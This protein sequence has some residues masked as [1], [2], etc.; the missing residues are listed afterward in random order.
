MNRSHYACF[1]VLGAIALASAAPAGE[2]DQGALWTSGARADFYSRA[3]GSRVMPLAWITALKQP[4]GRPF[5]EDSLGRYGYLPNPTSTPPGLPVGFSVAND[6]GG[7][8][9]GITCA[10]CHTREI[11]V[12]G[13]HYRIDGGPAIA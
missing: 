11:E 3:Q 12:T 2:I 10:A 9:L 4:D 6:S 7:E 8:V 1:A 13:I 5:I